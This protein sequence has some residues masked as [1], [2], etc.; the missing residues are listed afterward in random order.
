MTPNVSED[1]RIIPTSSVT[2]CEIQQAGK[3]P[4]QTGRTC[5]DC[6]AQ[7]TIASYNKDLMEMI[8]CE[9][10]DDPVGRYVSQEQHELW[11]QAVKWDEVENYEDKWSHLYGIRK[12]RWRHPLG[13]V[14]ARRMGG[15]AG[16]W[17]SVLKARFRQ[18]KY[19]IKDFDLQY[20]EPFENGTLQ[21]GDHPID[22]EINATLLIDGPRLG[23][24]IYDDAH[25]HESAKD[26]TEAQLLIGDTTG[27]LMRYCRRLQPYLPM[28]LELQRK[29]STSFTT[30][31]PQH[32][33]Y[34]TYKKYGRLPNRKREVELAEEEVKKPET[35]KGPPKPN[36]FG[37]ADS[38][39]GNKKRRTDLIA[40]TTSTGPFKYT[41]HTHEHWIFDTGAT[42]HVT[43]NDRY[44]FNI[45]AS[46]RTITVA[47]GTQ[48]PVQS[49]GELAIK[50]ICGAVLTL[51]AVCFVPE[52]KNVLSGSRLVQGKG[53]RVEIDSIGTRLICNEGTRPTLHM[54]YDKANELWYLVGARVRVSDTVC[55]VCSKSKSFDA[56]CNVMVDNNN[57]NNNKEESFSGYLTDYKSKTKNNKQ[58]K[59]SGTK[60][61]IK[62]EPKDRPKYME[63]NEAHQKFGHI[64]ERM[65]Q[66][67]AKRDN[68]VVTG[69]LQPCS[70]CLLY[71][72]T[73]R[74]VKKET[75]MKATY[76]GER[77]HMDV[78]GPFPTTLGGHRYWVMFKDQYSGMA[79]NVFVPKKDKVYEVTKEK[80]YYFAGLKK[81]IKYFRCDNAKE[82][83]QILRLCY[84]FGTTMEYTAPNTP[85][86]NGI[87]ERQFATDLRRA[88]SMMEP[89]DLTEHLRDLLRNEAIMSATTMANI[90]CND[91]TNRLSPF[92]KFYGKVPL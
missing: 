76:P 58:H 89:A 64:S 6:Y 73:Q 67:T 54:S 39:D 77:I 59:N 56:Q 62:T 52:A 46:E 75:D 78:S 74:P 70:A 32:P 35:K 80:F 43:N 31:T 53:H 16:G 28:S 36:S 83:G 87:V 7:I 71:K 51:K 57:N 84:I 17:R 81:K 63:I 41:G 26:A 4:L 29:L 66:V 8:Q 1:G 37:M 72:A 12:V 22:T 5:K 2:N 34:L 30:F 18:E 92:P 44:M 21:E 45:H 9:L 79:W 50:S 42:T 55:T 24:T 3:F 47:D 13:A 33:G 38:Q 10:T 68:I 60:E 85:Q 25:L 27:E 14:R 11:T 86:R 40:V 90:S 69:K 20:L 19:G 65:L 15:E 49:E 61:P 82:Y 48:Y 88:Q 91:V 23:F